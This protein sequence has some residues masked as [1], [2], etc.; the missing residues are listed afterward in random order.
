MEQLIE[1]IATRNL[2]IKGL[3]PKSL[4][5][6][7]SLKKFESEGFIDQVYGNR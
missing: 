6:H 5:D 2:K 4:V 7:S 1:L 3:P